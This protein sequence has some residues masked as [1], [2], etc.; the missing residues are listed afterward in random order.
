MLDHKAISST[1]L[2]R[3]GI[4]R[5]SL[6]ALPESGLA[7]SCTGL[8][9]Q[10]QL[11]WVS[12]CAHYIMSR[13]Q[14]FQC[15]FSFYKFYSWEF[16]TSI[17]WNMIIFKPIFSY[18][19]THPSDS[20]CLFIFSKALS[21]V[22]A[23]LLRDCGAC[24]EMWESCQWPL[25][26]EQQLSRP[27]QCQLAPLY[28]SEFTYEKKKWAFCLSADLSLEFYTTVR[29]PVSLPGFLYLHCSQL[30]TQTAG[31]S[32]AHFLPLNNRYQLCLAKTKNNYF[33]LFIWY[34][35]DPAWCALIYRI[36][37][38]LET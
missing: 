11:L 3:G 35:Q 21:P 29:K 19:F 9:R 26:R 7:S 23:A 27:Q 30:S 4:G 33:T 32:I 14:C 28:F 16:Q 25:L 12:K 17:Q 8:A 6:S 5:S 2:V 24:T 34:F 37:R 1:S 13:R 38:R 22:R 36:T 31:D 18:N 20:T 15:C 10:P